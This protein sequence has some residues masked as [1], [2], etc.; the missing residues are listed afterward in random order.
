M[1]GS[2]ITA[3]DE[4]ALQR[5]S[6]LTTANQVLGIF[7]K[8]VFPPFEPTGGISLVLDGIQ[9]P[10]NMGTIIRIADWFA[11]QHIVCSED[12]AD[13]FNPKVIQSTMGSIGRVQV[14]YRPLKSF[15]E[16]NPAIPVYA[17]VL[18]GRNVF[19]MDPISEGLLIIGNESKGISEELLQELKYERITIPKKGK[20]ESLN[21]AVATGIVLSHLTSRIT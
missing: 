17:M 11:V 7:K 8:P 14:L 12:S 18:E 9:D 13:A 1:P 20:A 6:F 3:I 4:S 16:A 21:A 10:G 5:I 2:M 15:F 19:T